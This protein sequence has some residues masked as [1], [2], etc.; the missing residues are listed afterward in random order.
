MV[1][2]SRVEGVGRGT[3]IVRPASQTVAIFSGR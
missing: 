1:E 3:F 2:K